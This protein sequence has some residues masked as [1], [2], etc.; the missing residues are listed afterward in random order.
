MEGCRSSA[1]VRIRWPG[2]ST[3][4]ETGAVTAP[5]APG[6][7]RVLGTYLHGPVLARNTAL[8]DVLLGWALAPVDAPEGTGVALEPLDD[9][10]ELALRSERLEAVERVGHGWRALARRVRVAR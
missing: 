6:P 7:G 3:A 9:Y 8:A 4:S 10:E 1:R 2:S 5:R